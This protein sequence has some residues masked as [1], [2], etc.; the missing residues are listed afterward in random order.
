MSIKDFLADK[1]KME[2]LSRAAFDSVDLDKNGIL[3][4]KELEALM[5]EVAIDFDFD[6]PTK[7]DVNE[8]HGDLASRADGIFSEPKF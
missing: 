6:P 8:M 5:N 2:K 4:A 7:E 1:E 3:D